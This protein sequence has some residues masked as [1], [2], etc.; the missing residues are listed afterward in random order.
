MSSEWLH[1]IFMF[2]VQVGVENGCASTL[3][4]SSLSH[5]PLSLSHS[6]Q[7]S[8]YVCVRQARVEH[9]QASLHRLS[10]QKEGQA[11]LQGPI[12]IRYKSY[13][14]TTRLLRD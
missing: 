8:F 13:V 9:F 3:T 6:K 4:L 1:P 10:S 7:E 2:C 5:P 12:P 11:K 14:A